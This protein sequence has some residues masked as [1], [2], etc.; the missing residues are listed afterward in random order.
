MGL[1]AKLRY[2]S[3][4][5]ATRVNR[6]FAARMRDMARLVGVALA[7]GRWQA[8]S[9][10]TKKDF[11]DAIDA[12]RF[13]ADVADAVECVDRCLLRAATGRVCDLRI[14]A[15][16]LPDIQHRI[17]DLFDTGVVPLSRLL[18][19]ERDPGENTG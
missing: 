13:A 17:L 12:A 3:R 15:P 5:A 7:T 2:M 19:R 1:E 14:R 4:R 16:S 8:L 18:N 11:A 10:K 9:V 6:D